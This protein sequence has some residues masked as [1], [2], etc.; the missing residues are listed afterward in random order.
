MG[1]QE[2][3]NTSEMKSF[4]DWLKSRFDTIEEK[5]KELEDIAIIERI[6]MMICRAISSG[7]AYIY[8]GP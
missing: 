1:L 6:M 8:L 2:L 4:L 3:E 5:I 7:L